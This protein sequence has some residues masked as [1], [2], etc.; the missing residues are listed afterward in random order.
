MEKLRFAIIGMGNRGQVYAKHQLIFPDRMQVVAIADN[1]QICLDAANKYL[2]LT[3]TML[4]QSADAILSQPKLADIMV[5]ATQDAQHREHAIR[6]MEIGYDLLLEKPISNRVEDIKQIVEVA[7]KLGRKVVI[8][9]VLRYTPFYQ[10]IKALIDQG[11]VGKILNV[12]AAEHVSCHHMAHAYVRGK[13]RKKA[14]SSPIILAKCCHDM[15]ILLWLTGKKC[16]KLT[17]FGS[18]DYFCED[19]CP[20]GAPERCE[21]GCPV[22]DC[23]YHAVKFYLSHIPGWP[24]KNMV[25]E[26]TEENILEILRT[27]QYGKCVFKQDNDVV[28]HQTVNMLLED[29]VTVSFNM[30][31]MHTRATR[32]IRIGGTKGEI[33]GDL[34]DKKVYW[35]SHGQQ[36]QCIDISEQLKTTS[37]HSGGDTGIVRDLI[38]YYLEPDFDSG[39][40]TT[41][42]RSAESHYVA[43][44]AEDSRASGGQLIHMDT[45]IKQIGQ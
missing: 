21:E 37:G 18:L 19:N 28:D 7:N 11:V 32:T 3:E 33:W 10:Q 4:F 16:E 2:H 17:S 6:A 38:R 34:H 5:I 30:N 42:D 36:V 22:E 26:P 41:L 35:Q 45:Y 1:R 24:T 44:A 13:W 23:P 12:E 20:E 15:D 9:H 25:P 40:I 8:A 39:Y 31:A 27:T 29:G 43:F 14:D